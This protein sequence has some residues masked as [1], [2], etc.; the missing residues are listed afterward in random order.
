MRYVKGVVVSCPV[1]LFTICV[2]CTLMKRHIYVTGVKH[3]REATGPDHWDLPKGIVLSPEELAAQL[4]LSQASGSRKILD[5]AASKK[6]SESAEQPLCNERE[7]VLSHNKAAVYVFDARDGEQI[8]VILEVRGC[9][10]GPPLLPSKS[11][12]GSVRWTPPADS[13][14]HFASYLA[15]AMNR[16]TGE[17]WSL[18]VLPYLSS[19]Y[20]VRY[21]AAIKD[22]TGAKCG[23]SS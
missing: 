12:D 22:K 11:E 16:L 15:M 19:N 20:L 1:V 5:L 8:Y 14:M 7:V 2:G 17:D 23:M 10:A 6:N 9:T 21:Q 4:Q 18:R 3:G 13:Y